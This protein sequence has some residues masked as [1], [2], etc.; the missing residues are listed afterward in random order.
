VKVRPHQL[1][2]EILYNNLRENEG[3]AEVMIRN[4]MNELRNRMEKGCIKEIS[5]DIHAGIIQ[6]IELFNS[7]KDMNMEQHVIVTEKL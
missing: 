3:N 6:L 2:S 1:F 5:D 4:A 7:H